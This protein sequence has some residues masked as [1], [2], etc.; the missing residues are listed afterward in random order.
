MA[1]STRRAAGSLAIA[2]LLEQVRLACLRPR[3][4]LGEWAT[5]ASQLRA[6]I[7][8]LVLGGALRRATG[9]APASQR[10]IAERAAAVLPRAAASVQ[11]AG[12]GVPS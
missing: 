7:D 10:P 9:G 2:H 5:S 3:A 4:A 6:G 1:G 11:Y 12:R 8:R